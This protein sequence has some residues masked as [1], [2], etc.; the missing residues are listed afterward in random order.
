[1]ALKPDRDYNESSDISQRWSS[2]GDQA[3][4]AKGGIA[5][6]ETQGS[7]VALGSTVNVVRY[8]VDPSG[9]IP[10]GILL[11]DVVATPSNGIKNFQS[12]EVWP[13]EAVT[14]V[15]KGWVVTNMITGSAPAVG[16]VAYV[17]A[18]GLISKTQA[19]GAKAI[20]RFETTLDADGYAK[21]SILL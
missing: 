9:A 1:M 18:S 12:L 16:D 8:A 7:G 3:P 15:T 6:V 10:K 17:A 11:Q 14:L 5:C 21:V 20:G 19:T 13:G 2:A 4:K